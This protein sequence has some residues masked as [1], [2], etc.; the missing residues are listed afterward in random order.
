MRQRNKEII[1]Y[2]RTTSEYSRIKANHE[3]ES[4]RLFLTKL[5]YRGWCY[6]NKVTFRYTTHIHIL[7]NGL[8]IFLVSW[9][10]FSKNVDDMNT[11]NQT[12]PISL[13]YQL[14]GIV[15]HDKSIEIYIYIFQAILSLLPW[16]YLN[17]WSSSAPHM[18]LTT[19]TQWE[20]SKKY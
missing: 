10:I 6:T 15:K 14:E 16:T 7:M 12:E 1:T 4:F 13:S 20:W 9:A 19:W 11:G 8:A 5:S 3:N 18:I 2:I 17:W